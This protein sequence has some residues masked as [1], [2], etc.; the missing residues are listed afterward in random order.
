MRTDEG[1]GTTVGVVKLWTAATDYV[2]DEVKKLPIT[3]DPAVARFLGHRINIFLTLVALIMYSIAWP[4]LSQTHDVRPAVMPIVAAFAAFPIMLGWSNPTLGWAISV[5]SAQ[6]IGL[7]IDPINDWNYT[8]QVVHLIEI[9]VL[10]V[11]AYLRAPL[12]L[13]PVFWAV[14]SFVMYQA[15]PPEAQ[16]G[17]VVGLSIVAIICVLIRIIVRSRVAL[18]QQTVL[19][20][21]EKSKNAVLSER[22]RIARDLHDVVAHRM[23]V[24]VVQAQTAKYRVDGV[25]EEAAAEF[26][27]IADVAREALDEVRMMLGV[28]RLED[29]SPGAEAYARNPNPGLEQ[30]DGIVAATRGAGVDVTYQPLSTG[31]H[32]GDT[33]ALVAYRI[34]QESLANTTRYAVGAQVTVELSVLGDDLNVTIANTAS[35]GQP[36]NLE[37]SGG[38]GI[39]GMIER[40][41]A[42]G[43]VLSAAPQPDGGFV[44][45]ARLPLRAVA[46]PELPRSDNS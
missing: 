15:T 44:V 10:T 26:D 8:I 43:G 4:T 34:V 1:P 17:W 23:S 5:V 35:T 46:A 14:S 6:L 39:P 22:T 30:I 20:D 25:G 37:S 2:A 40:A 3:V 19:K 27:A 38:Q 31:E 7:T 16:A 33:C 13:L 21:T 29:D 42:V 24:V 28:L 45:R 12:R 41:K 36:I 11:L 9:L 18:A 32:V